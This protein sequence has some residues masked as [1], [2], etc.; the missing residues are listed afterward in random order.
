MGTTF[1]T[2]SERAHLGAED[3]LGLGPVEQRRESGHGLQQLDSVL[4]SGKALV[5]LQKRHDPLEIPEVVRRGLPLDVPVHGVFEQDGA[6]DPLAGEARAGDDARAHLMHSRKHFVLVG[7]GIFFDSVQR[8]RLRSTAA[9]LIESRYEPGLGL[10]FLKLLLEVAHR[11]HRES[12]GLRGASNALT[13]LGACRIGL[14]RL[15]APTRAERRLGGKGRRARCASFDPDNGAPILPSA[16]VNHASCGRC[17][18]RRPAPAR[19]PLC[20]LGGGI[21]PAPGAK[22]PAQPPAHALKGALAQSPSGGVE[23]AQA[24]EERRVAGQFGRHP[25]GQPPLARWVRSWR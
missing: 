10:H 24:R 15:S 1:Q 9:A 18:R 6:Q 4:H 13:G 23:A 11:D 16:P 5:H 14:R 3:A 20:R 25:R 12:M 8:Q 7:P 21:P 19:W 22:D 17:I 2:A